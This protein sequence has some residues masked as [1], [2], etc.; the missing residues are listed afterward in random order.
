MGSIV[1]EGDCSISGQTYTGCP[2]GLSQFTGDMKKRL[3]MLGVGTRIDLAEMYVGDDCKLPIE[4]VYVCLELAGMV[5][6]GRTAS[7]FVVWS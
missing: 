3:S 2:S 1:A 5:G 7:F 6:C 4:I